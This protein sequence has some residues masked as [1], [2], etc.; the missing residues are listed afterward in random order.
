[1]GYRVC[2]LLSAHLSPA[3]IISTSY[4]GAG[5]TYMQA[6]TVIVEARNNLCPN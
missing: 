4:P 6:Q 2:G 5:I 1:M 3:N